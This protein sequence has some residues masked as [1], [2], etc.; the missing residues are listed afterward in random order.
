MQL[1]CVPSPGTVTVYRTE[2]ARVFL[3]PVAPRPA[4]A[5][6]RA[7]EEAQKGNAGDQL[8]LNPDSSLP[9]AAGHL[10]SELRGLRPRETE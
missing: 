7:R 9:L 6:G 3:V 1:I 8:R 5:S 10:H 2:Q 4:E